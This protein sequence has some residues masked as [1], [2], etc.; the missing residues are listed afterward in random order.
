MSTRLKPVLLK[1]SFFVTKFIK[2]KDPTVPSR[3]FNI[4]TSYKRNLERK[5]HEVR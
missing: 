1:R 3:L 4:I 2:R 5:A